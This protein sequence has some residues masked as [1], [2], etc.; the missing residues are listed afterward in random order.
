MTQR[1]TAQHHPRRDGN[2]LRDEKVALLKRQIDNGK[3]ETEGKFD[4]IINTFV[5]EFIR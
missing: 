2:M 4:K 5:Q 1:K 3:Y